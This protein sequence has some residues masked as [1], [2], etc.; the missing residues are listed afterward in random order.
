MSEQNG[1]MQIPSGMTGFALPDG[2]CFELDLIEACR[3][4]DK[5]SLEC[6]EKKNYEH[7]DLFIAWIGQQ[8]DGHVRLNLAQADW[9]IDQIMVERIRKKKAVEQSAK[10][11]SSTESI[12]SGLPP[13]SE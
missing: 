5:I 9:L 7:L 10:S 8:T 4:I 1:V 2:D 13:I 11:L 6:A 12:P 3:A